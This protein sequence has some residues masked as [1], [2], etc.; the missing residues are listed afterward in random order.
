MEYQLSQ[1][2]IQTQTVGIAQ[3]KAQVQVVRDEFK[4]YDNETKRLIAELKAKQAEK[5]VALL[6][7]QSLERREHGKVWESV[8]RERLYNRP[9]NRVMVLRHQQTLLAVQSRFQEADRVTRI[10][11][12]ATQFEQAEH[13][14]SRQR[15][16]AESLAQLKAKQAAELEFFD[17]HAIVEISQ[18][19]QKRAVLRK[20]IENKEKKVDAKGVL[21]KDI[22]RYWNT[23]QTARQDDIAAGRAFGASLPSSQLSPTELAQNEIG[24]LILP[25]LKLEKS[26]RS[27]RRRK[28]AA[29]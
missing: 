28:R 5:R 8:R 24:F 3:H 23:G 20:S 9:S 22:E 27:S 1:A 12:D 13:A 16:Y 19:E 6:E 21:V 25:P 7:Q 18:I 26:A 14:T 2:K 10:I 17:E 4:A 11:Q 29:D 15:D